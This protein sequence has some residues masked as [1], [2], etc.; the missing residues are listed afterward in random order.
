M[1]ALPAVPSKSS[2][3]R[4]S[5]WPN[6]K[7]CQGLSGWGR[8]GHRGV[9]RHVPPGQLR[10]QCLPVHHCRHGQRVLRPTQLRRGHDMH[11]LPAA[12]QRRLRH[13]RASVA[14]LGHAHV[15]AALGAAG[16]RLSCPWAL[17]ALRDGV[18]DAQYTVLLKHAAPCCFFPPYS[19]LALGHAALIACCGPT[20]E[21]DCRPGDKHG[22]CCICRPMCSGPARDCTVPLHFE[23]LHGSCTVSQALCLHACICW[24][25]VECF[26]ASEGDGEVRSQQQEWLALLPQLCAWR[27]FQVKRHTDLTIFSGW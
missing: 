25:L 4:T 10:R 1:C 9:R 2:S 3:P 8:A 24:I 23:V 22:V 11:I 26:G 14:R 16:C 13:N 18:T 20:Y 12:G 7:T 27:V 5:A 21:A 15:P 6:A 17:M 19:G